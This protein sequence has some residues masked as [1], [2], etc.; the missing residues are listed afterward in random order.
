MCGC[1]YRVLSKVTK[2]SKVRASSKVG[3]V[4]REI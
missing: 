4:H 2:N 3:K 1:R